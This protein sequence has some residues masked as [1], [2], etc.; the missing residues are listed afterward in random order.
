[1]QVAPDLLNKTERD[2]IGALEHKCSLRN[3]LFVS[4]PVCNSNLDSVV[5]PDQQIQWLSTFR[6]QATSRVRTENNELRRKYVA[7]FQRLEADEAFARL[8]LPVMQKYVRYCIL[9]PYRTEISFWGCSCLPKC[10]NPNVQ[11]HSRINIYWQE[12]LY[13]GINIFLRTPVYGFYV[14]K[15]K[16]TQKDIA[17]F[18][19]ECLTFE[20]YDHACPNK[21]LKG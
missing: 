11:I 20:L 21:L 1:M 17:R 9:E 13:V 16:L 8:S 3:I 15:S 2:C 10:N 4:S 18:Q 14:T 5:S 7:R 12:V 6:Q 19:K